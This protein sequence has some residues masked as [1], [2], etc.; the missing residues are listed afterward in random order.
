MA[1]PST[2]HLRKQLQKECL[3]ALQYYVLSMQESC[4]LL[5]EVHEN[6]L[7]PDD[8]REKILAHRKQELFAYAAYAQ[9]QKRLWTL[10]TEFDPRLVRLPDV[11]PAS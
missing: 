1:S 8:E 5:C 10:L 3:R 4:E 9:A 11:L 6:G 2:A 7:I